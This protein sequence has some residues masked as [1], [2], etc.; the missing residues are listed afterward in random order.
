MPFTLPIFNRPCRSERR[1]RKVAAQLTER[2]FGLKIKVHVR[3]C[4]ASQIVVG[5]GKI[6]NSYTGGV[7]FGLD[8]VYKVDHSKVD[9]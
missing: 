8:L 6:E 2:N 3:K 5:K 7:G 4:E 1:V 9:D